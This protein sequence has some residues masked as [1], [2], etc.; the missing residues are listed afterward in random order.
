[1]K[2]KAA[3]CEKYIIEIN[4]TMMQMNNDKLQLVYQDIIQQ[5][6][7]Q[8]KNKVAYY[9]KLFDFVKKLLDN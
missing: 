2:Q 4:Q 7:S 3:Q 1:D 6:N 8:E 9:Q 5:S